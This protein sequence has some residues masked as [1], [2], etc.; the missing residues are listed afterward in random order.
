M[1]LALE[2]MLGYV[3]YACSPAMLTLAA[4]DITLNDRCKMLKLHLHNF[5]G[6]PCVVKDS[7][8][9]AIA[10]QVWC[11]VWSKS[12]NGIH[13]EQNSPNEQPD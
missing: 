1:M 13:L 4:Y 3:T 5:T 6:L 12:K 9:W 10:V 8:Y 2:I 7:F 11:L